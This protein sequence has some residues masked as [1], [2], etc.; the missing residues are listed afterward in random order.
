ML[1]EFALYNYKTKICVVRSNLKKYNFSIQCH[2][3][4]W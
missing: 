2:H 3:N 1:A 4:T